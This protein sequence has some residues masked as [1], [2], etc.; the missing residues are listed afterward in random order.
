MATGRERN[1]AASSLEVRADL[2]YA[3]LKKLKRAVQDAGK[4][5]RK[6]VRHRLKAAGEIVQSEI[7]SRAPVYGGSYGAAKRRA[8]GKTGSKR[9][10]R[11]AKH[12]PGLLKKST[13]LKMGS[14]SVAVYNDAR[15]FTAKWQGYRYGRRL[16]FDTKYA[17]K[18]AFFY[19]GFEAGKPRA[20]AAISKV[21]D[22]IERDYLKGG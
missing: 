2:D 14:L 12:A 10:V 1:W 17:G 11:A 13:R 9:G 16:E 8:V 5:A 6:S 19:P 21:L 4:D 15:A 7:T 3:Q 20:V 18:Y 22:D